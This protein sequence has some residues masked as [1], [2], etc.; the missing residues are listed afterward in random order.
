VKQKV[1]KLTLKILAGYVIAAA[2]ISYRDIPKFKA[3]MIPIATALSY[4]DIPSIV[5]GFYSI[6]TATSNFGLVSSSTSL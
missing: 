5:A 3:R 1:D 4:R 2:V 6:A